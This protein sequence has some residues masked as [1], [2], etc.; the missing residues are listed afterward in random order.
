MNSSGDAAS[1][2]GLDATLTLC[3]H[4]CGKQ[5]VLL[6]RSMD[7][8]ADPSS[9]S[10]AMRIG[11]GCEVLAWLVRGEGQVL[12][13]VNSLH[14]SNRRRFTVAHECGHLLLHAGETFIDKSFRVNWRDGVSSLAVDRHEIEANQ[15]AAELLMPFEM[16]VADLRNNLLDELIDR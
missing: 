1:F 6:R 9:H 11:P 7:I 2:A 4:V 16:V 5:R 15:F 8:R 3:E 14:H 13:G 10:T 12:I